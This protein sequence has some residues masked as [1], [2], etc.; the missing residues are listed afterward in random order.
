MNETKIE[1]QKETDT[2]ESVDTRALGQ[3]TDISLQDNQSVDT[4]APGQNT[5]ISLQ[6]N[7]S[8]GTR[9]PAVRA[10]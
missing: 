8:V 7:Q 4:R 6:D 9:A 2:K 1:K 5:D 10:R 3:N